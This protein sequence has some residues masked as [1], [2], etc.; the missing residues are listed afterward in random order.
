MATSVESAAR[1]MGRI[2]QAVISS[3]RTRCACRK[4]TSHI[5]DQAS[6]D[7]LK[8]NMLILILCRCGHE[9][10]FE[11][12]SS[13][14]S[15]NGG[16]NSCP[17]CRHVLFPTAPTINDGFAP[18]LRD[19]IQDDDVDIAESIASIHSSLS[20]IHSSLSTIHSILST[21]VIT[22]SE[23]NRAPLPTLPR[24]PPVLTAPRPGLLGSNPV[25]PNQR[26]RT[27][28]PPQRWS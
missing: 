7:T 8:R 21:S 25:A 22:P 20:R 23:P 27:S 10:G 28:S 5:S 13:W 6:L 18:L 3:R 26:R 2:L 11:C 16:H 1:N 17:N 19:N 9:F 15:P 24:L 4:C 12:I 14:L